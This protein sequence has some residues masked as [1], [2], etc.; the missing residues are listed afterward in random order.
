MR[1]S[2]DSKNKSMGDPKNHTMV[3]S[4]GESKGER[5]LGRVYGRV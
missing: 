5:I 2:K 1:E 3:E 4:K